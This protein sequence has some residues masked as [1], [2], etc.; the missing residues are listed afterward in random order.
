MAGWDYDYQAGPAG[1]LTDLSDYVVGV[2]IPNE[3]ST[4][5]RGTNP[6]V[7]Y[8]H[9]TQWASRKFVR[10]SALVL[11]VAVRE[12]NAAG[13]VTHTDG[14]PGHIYEN[15]SV[16]KRIL[17]GN[18]G[19]LVRLQRDAPHQ[20][21]V[22]L[23]VE[24]LGEAFPTQTRH[25]FGFPLT[26]PHP[27]WIG[28]ADTGNTASPL[29]V[30]GD[31]PVGDAVVRLLTGT[32]TKLTVDSTGDFLQIV[33]AMPAGGVS[34]DLGAGTCVKVTGGADYSNALRRSNAFELDPGSNAVTL[35][36]GTMSVDWNEQWR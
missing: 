8:R 32:D 13:A 10:P 11:E 9:G 20:G 16:L 29:V 6:I 18:A 15:L 24:Q 21:T 19:S 36:T 12:T 26:A 17:G 14:K 27:F 35:S 5:R 2:R 4:G 23:D 25:I 22:Y 30:G 31:A 1:S 34:I 28:A 33:G 3:Y 7:Q